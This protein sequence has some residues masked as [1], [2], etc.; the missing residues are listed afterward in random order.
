VL[1]AVFA[2]TG[3][4]SSPQAFS[5]GFVAATGADTGRIITHLGRSK[6]HPP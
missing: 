1:V 6:S 2:S 5:D 3:S 4:Y